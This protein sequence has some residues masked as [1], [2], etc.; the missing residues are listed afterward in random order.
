MTLTVGE[1]PE[2]GRPVP[3]REGLGRAGRGN[4]LYC[5]QA[6][7]AA[8]AHPRTT[9]AGRLA[10]LDLA[11]EGRGR[12]RRVRGYSEATVHRPVFLKITGQSW[13]VF[14]REPWGIPWGSPRSPKRAVRRGVRLH[15]TE[16]FTESLRLR[17]RPRCQRG[18]GMSQAWPSVLDPMPQQ[19]AL[20]LTVT[21]ASTLPHGPNEFSEHT[22]QQSHTH[23]QFPPCPPNVFPR[24]RGADAGEVCH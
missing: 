2:A 14:R 15:S 6:S 4:S 7:A 11:L 13:G 24:E 12:T 16:T 1:E 21:C 22:E 18:P 9:A 5:A 23:Q 17:I 19:E 8:L 20:A 3:G 10:R